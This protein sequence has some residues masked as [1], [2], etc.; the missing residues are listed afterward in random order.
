MRRPNVVSAA[1]LAVAAAIAMF[2]ETNH[3]GCVAAALQCLP[4]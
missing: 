4:R 3:P 2:L 1:L